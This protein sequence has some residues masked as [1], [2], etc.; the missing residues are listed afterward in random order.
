MRGQ[1]KLRGKVLRRTKRTLVFDLLG[2]SVKASPKNR[3]RSLGSY[4]AKGEEGIEWTFEP[5]KEK[6]TTW[7][8]FVARGEPRFED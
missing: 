5:V 4:G 2:T 1:I 8:E 3:E 7:E 6:L